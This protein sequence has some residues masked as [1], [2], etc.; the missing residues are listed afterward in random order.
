M[1]VNY[2]KLWKLLIDK[3]MNKHDLHI[4]SGI[5]TSTISKMSNGK[6]VSLEV[7]ERICIVLDCKI[8]DI[9]EFRGEK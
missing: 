8:S 9:I 2:K 1:S 3:D 7:L 5:S 6:Y 4:K